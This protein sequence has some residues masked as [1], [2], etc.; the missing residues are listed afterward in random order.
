MSPLTW[1]FIS[2]EKNCRD[3]II[4]ILR[5]TADNF[6]DLEKRTIEKLTNDKIDQLE[7]SLKNIFGEDPD[8]FW[9]KILRELYV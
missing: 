9:E 6:Y 5:Y 8:E 3:D 7:I 4:D 2:G 1:E